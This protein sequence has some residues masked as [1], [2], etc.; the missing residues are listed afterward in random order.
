MNVRFHA[1]PKLVSLNPPD[2]KS[3]QENKV[4]DKQEEEQVRCKQTWDVQAPQ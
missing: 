4:D 1:L 2:L 3:L